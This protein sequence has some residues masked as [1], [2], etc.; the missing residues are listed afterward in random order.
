[1][2]HALDRAMQEGERRVLQVFRSG[3]SKPR[4][5]KERQVMHR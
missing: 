1:M 3:S 2:P 4:N 5:K